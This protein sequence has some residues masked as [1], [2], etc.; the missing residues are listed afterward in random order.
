MNNDSLFFAVLSPSHVW[1]INVDAE[2]IGGRNCEKEQQRDNR[3]P[4][5][6]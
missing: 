2:E 5:L 6:T 3:K 4:L 1:A